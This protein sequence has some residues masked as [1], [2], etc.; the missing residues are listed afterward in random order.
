MIAVEKS[1]FSA[2]MISMNLHLP[3]GRKVFSVMSEIF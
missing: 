2:T 3:E 1:P